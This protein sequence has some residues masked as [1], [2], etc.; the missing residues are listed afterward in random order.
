MTRCAGI[1][2][3][4]R[5]RTQEGL[6]RTSAHVVSL[7]SVGTP[8]HTNLLHWYQEGN[9]QARFK[10]SRTRKLYAYCNRHGLFEC[11]DFKK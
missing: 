4:G 6:S 7:R 9:A 10:I 5:K 2:G 8:P 11:A 3:T 1:P